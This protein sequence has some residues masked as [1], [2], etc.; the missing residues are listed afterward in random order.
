MKRVPREQLRNNSQAVYIGR[1][2]GE[3]D[4]GP[5]PPVKAPTVGEN[6]SREEVSDGAHAL[7]SDNFYNSTIT[8]SPSTLIG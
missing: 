4:Q 5:I 3:R 2:A 1:D 6:P 7:E 8:A